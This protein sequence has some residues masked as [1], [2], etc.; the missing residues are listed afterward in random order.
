VT[1]DPRGTATAVNDKQEL[2]LAE[3][4]VRPGAGPEFTLR[5]PYT[6]VKNQHAWANVVEHGRFS[7]RRG[8]TVRNLYLASSEAQVLAA[9]QHELGAG[10]RTWRTIFAQYGYIPSGIGTQSIPVRLKLT[11]DDFSDSGGYAHL[12]AAGA[13]WLLCLEGKRNWELQAVPQ[14]LPPSAVPVQPAK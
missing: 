5:L 14:N 7:I 2:L 13:E 4:K 12:I 6:V 10:L 3:M 1:F 11:F 9:L 8:D